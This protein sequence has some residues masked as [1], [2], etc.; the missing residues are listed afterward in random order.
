LQRQGEFA[1]L[2]QSANAGKMVNLR[3][4]TRDWGNLCED[5]E[6]VRAAVVPM[7]MIMRNNVKSAPGAA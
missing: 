6:G 7:T 3:G 1:F 2:H 5:G 4:K